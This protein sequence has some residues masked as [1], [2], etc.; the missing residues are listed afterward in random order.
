MSV[1]ATVFVGV[2]IAVLGSAS[3]TYVL[4]EL[5][6]NCYDACLAKGMNCNPAIETDS[7]THLFE[8]LNVTCKKLE[9]G[10]WWANDQPSFEPSTGTC[11]G[12][13]NVPDAVACQGAYPTVQRVCRCDAPRTGVSRETFGAGYS[14]GFVNM[15]ERTMF[16]WVLPTDGSQ[17]A[18]MTHMWLTP[19]SVEDIISYYV[20]GETKASISFQPALA[21]GVGFTDQGDIDQKA[22]WGLKWFGKGAKTGAWFWNFRVP[23]TRSI[24]VTMYTTQNTTGQTLYLILRGSSNLGLKIAGVDIPPNAKLMQF[25]TDAQFKALDFVTL[26]DVPAGKGLLFMQTISVVSGNLNFLE[27]CYHQFT[28]Y[29]QS[30]P[31]T[32]LSTGT[33]DFFDSAYYFDGGQFRLPVSGFTHFSN[34]NNTINWSAYRFHDQDPILFEDGFRFVWRI[35]D[36]SDVSGIKCLIKSGGIPNGSPQDSYVKAYTWVYV[37]A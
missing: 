22:P 15:Q 23:F 11:I 4:G 35:G 31:G 14:Q 20:D 32:V 10:P 29:N 26:A 25:T 3:A 6:L 30:W 27:A 1:K 7:N 17:T 36:M 37:W 33:E 34:T 21:C 5:G 9:P 18:Q 13:Q 2:L 16:S 8:Q 12:Y 24:R 19:S 28:P